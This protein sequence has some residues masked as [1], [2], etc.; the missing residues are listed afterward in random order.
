MSASTKA[1]PS[2]E[3]LA[4]YSEFGMDDNVERVSNRYNACLSLVKTFSFKALPTYLEVIYGGKKNAQA[5]IDLKAM[6]KKHDTLFA[7]SGTDRE[8]QVLSSIILALLLKAESEMALIAAMS[9]L[10]SS[11]DGG[12]KLVTLPMEL[13]SLAETAVQQISI[14]RRKRISITSLVPED[15]EDL[16]AIQS[17][18]PEPV[19]EE[20]EEP[21]EVENSTSTDDD[22]PEHLETSAARTIVDATLEFASKTQKLCA[23]L[24]RRLEIQDEELDILWWLYGERSEDTG[25][26]FSA[27]TDL[28]RSLIFGKELAEL[29][30]VAPGP[31]SIKSVLLKAG[32]SETKKSVSN[33]I[34]AVD[35]EWIDECSLDGLSVLMLPIHTAIACRKE[36]NHAK[37]WK[38]TWAAKTQ[39]SKSHSISA[40]S[41][42]HL[43]YFERLLLRIS[44]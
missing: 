34:D 19:S 43:F 18:L 36:F 12:R 17:E 3:F 40:L 2:D 10:T 31:V 24:V 29:T 30:K 28:Q 35:N 13:L 22:E 4:W 44:D 38:E 33:S 5:L 39:I 8:V 21:D 9:I 11:L 1:K 15:L 20:E 26:L 41:L 23:D 27:V 16:T 32:V 25:K 6:L 7:M 37:N 14:D 42:A